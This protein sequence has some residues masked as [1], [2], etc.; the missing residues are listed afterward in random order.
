[1]IW[2]K[3]PLFLGWHPYTISGHSKTTT[4]PATQYDLGQEVHQ[5]SLARLALELLN[6]TVTLPECNLYTGST[7]IY[8]YIYIYTNTP[9]AGRHPKRIPKETIVVQPF[10]LAVVL[11]CIYIHTQNLQGLQSPIY[12][13]Y[14]AKIDRLIQ[15]V[16]VP[17]M[18]LSYFAEVCID[19]LTISLTSVHLLFLYRSW[20]R[21]NMLPAPGKRYFCRHQRVRRFVHQKNLK[22]FSIQHCLTRDTTAKYHRVLFSWIRSS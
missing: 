10:F 8:I 11:G 12:W 18:P 2:G 1:M 16:H 7:Y 20:Q 4:L 19:N 6:Y 17:A 3:N 9:R 15:M 22:V 5:K 14:I 13:K 21:N